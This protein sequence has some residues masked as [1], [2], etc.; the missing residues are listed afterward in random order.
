MN[1]DKK[2]LKLCS[3]LCSVAAVFCILTGHA[4]APQV[5]EV[6]EQSTEVTTESTTMVT[7]ETTTFPTTESTTVA[8]WQTFIAT[9][10]CSCTKCCGKWGLNRPTDVNGNSIV[11]TA[12]GAIATANHTVSADI[13]VLPFGTVIEIEGYGIYTVEDTG[14]AIIGNR[15]DVYYDS[16]ELALKSGLGNK[17]VNVRIIQEV[18]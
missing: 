14:S 11:L 3:S 18:K 2:R 16:H 6:E 12:S 1:R 5:T 15:L 17:R 8:V 7:T 13:S 10:Y 4:C 9:A